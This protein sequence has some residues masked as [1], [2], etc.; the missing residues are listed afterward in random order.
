MDTNTLMEL[1]NSYAVL[2]IPLTLGITQIVKQFLPE[3]LLTKWT[4]V[5]SLII[6]I[7]SAMLVV[8]VSKNGIL[9]GI[10]IGLS[11][12]GLWSTINGA[13]FKK[14]EKEKS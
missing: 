3:S 9:V 13:I 7:C 5:V 11:A 2:L 4:P 1:V 6:A 14:V 12:S 8:G 10:I